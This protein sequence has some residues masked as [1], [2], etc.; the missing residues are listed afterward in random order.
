MSDIRIQARYNGKVYDVA[1]LD[2]W[3]D[4]EQA[5]C[6]LASAE[7][8]LFG[9]YLNEVEIVLNP[10]LSKMAKDVEYMHNFQNEREDIVEYIY[11]THE[12]IKLLKEELK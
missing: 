10:L 11:K 3:G 6:D 5:T 9:I 8:E 2:M 12:I 4:P 7:E 1:K